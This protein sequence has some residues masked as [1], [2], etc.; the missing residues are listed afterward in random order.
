MAKQ[1]S[2]GKMLEVEFKKQNFATKIL[3]RNLN[4]RRFLGVLKEDC[5]LFLKIIF[6][7]FLFSLYFLFY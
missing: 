2:N 1:A 6:P 3:K 4:E 7:K 5:F